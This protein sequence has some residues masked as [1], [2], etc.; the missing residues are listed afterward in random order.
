MNLCVFQPIDSECTGPGWLPGAQDIRIKIPGLKALMSH[1][2]T[3]GTGPGHLLAFTNITILWG[4]LHH[5]SRP[6]RHPFPSLFY[7]HQHQWKLVYRSPVNFMIIFLVTWFLKPIIFIGSDQINDLHPGS[8]CSWGSSNGPEPAL[9]CLQ[10]K[11]SACLPSS[12]SFKSH[13]W[14]EKCVERLRGA[15][16]ASWAAPCGAFR[17]NCEP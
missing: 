13:N 7:K 15:P 12:L 4:W 10:T 5:E 8:N 16:P 3:P 1:V 14:D 11:L 6:T 17:G 9:I 2:P